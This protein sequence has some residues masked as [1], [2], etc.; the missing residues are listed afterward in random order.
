MWWCNHFSLIF[1]SSGS[2]ICIPSEAS[3]EAEERH[4][5]SVCFYYSLRARCVS[6]VGVC[7]VSNVDCDYAYISDVILF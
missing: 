3:S 2:S 6:D 1:P 5:A 4:A 7:G